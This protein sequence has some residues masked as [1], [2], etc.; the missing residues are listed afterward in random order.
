MQLLPTRPTKSWLVT[1]HA[2]GRPVTAAERVRHDDFVTK[3]I[4]S[5]HGEE[6]AYAVR[7]ADDAAEDAAV[8]ENAAETVT[9]DSAT[10]T[11]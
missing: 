4:A 6:F 8:A 9:A 2:G 1:E 3:V 11:A 7:I 10:V 5:I